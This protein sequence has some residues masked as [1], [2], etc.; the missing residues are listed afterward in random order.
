MEKRLFFKM[1]EK[2]IIR[3]RINDDEKWRFVGVID[4]KL[5]LSIYLREYYTSV[6]NLRVCCEEGGCGS[7]TVLFRQNSKEFDSGWKAI[8]SC[9]RL[10]ISC[11]ESHII[12][13][14]TFFTESL[15]RS[16]AD[17]NGVQCGFCSPGIL[18]STLSHLLNQK[19][20]DE[21]QESLSNYL[22]GHLCRCTGYRPILTSLSSKKT[23]EMALRDIEDTPI[24]FLPTSPSSNPT[25]DSSRKPSSCDSCD[26]RNKCNP[27][28]ASQDEYWNDPSFNL[29]LPSSSRN[30]VFYCPSTIDEILSIYHDQIITPNNHKSIHNHH[31]K[32]TIV[33]F[34]AANTSWGIE[35]Y[36]KPTTTKT[37]EEKIVSIDLNQVTELKSY[38]L[39]PKEK[40][41]IVNSMVTIDQLSKL[42]RTYASCNSSWIEASNHLQCIG[43]K[44]IRTVATWGGNIV[45]ALRYPKQFTSDLL[46]ILFGL[47]NVKITVIEF[48]SSHY[49][50]APNR[51]EYDLESFYHAFSFRK[52]DTQNI[53][54]LI[55]SISIENTYLPFHNDNN[56]KTKLSKVNGELN[57]DQLALQY[58]VQPHDIM[59]TKL[60]LVSQ[61]YRVSPRSSNSYAYAA[62]FVVAQLKKKKLSEKVGKKNGTEIIHIVN[63]KIVMN[64]IF[65]QTVR[66]K[67]CELAMTCYRGDIS[68]LWD[69]AL[70]AIKQDIQRVQKNSHR[71]NLSSHTSLQYQSSAISALLYK[72][73][74]FLK[75]DSLTRIDNKHYALE[76]CKNNQDV[77][78]VFVRSINNLFLYFAS[79]YLTHYLLQ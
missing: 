64:G 5:R 41:L 38:I 76:P 23:Q 73:F 33:K 45:M 16:L 72:F 56:D 10:L 30:S 51:K 19:K 20:C 43:N 68:T 29:E 75:K 3:I 50:T 42:I 66:A 79:L 26:H 34:I 7:C 31:E 37:R 14:S 77:V 39:R 58:S 13:T 28:V 57:F 11:D 44:Q 60:E 61:A 18:M 70:S 67:N 65:N 22:D 55:H 2:K 47:Q 49:T 53:D 54:F 21:D 71:D 24:S 74:L 8:H 32:H 9:L 12:T 15:A 59:E 63:V 40:R 25:S 62:L 4:N 35:K 52:N 46:L 6:S 27:S 48:S 1:K 69:Q 36:F 78:R 17:G